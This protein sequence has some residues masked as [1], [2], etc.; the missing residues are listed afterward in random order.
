MKPFKK[1]IPVLLTVALVFSP[2]EFLSARTAREKAPTPPTALSALVID[3]A[4]GKILWSKEPDHLLPPASTT[5]LLTALVV[6]DELSLDQVVTVDS[7]VVGTPP[8][9]I[10]LRAGERF[11]VQDLLRALLIAS[12]NDAARALAIAAAGSEYEFAQKM[13]RKAK[14][15]GAHNSR[16]VKASGLPAEGQVSTAYDLMQIF[17]QVE[18]NS[19]FM[20]ALAVK[21]AVIRSLD[22]RSFRLKNH[23]KLL[24]R[25]S[26]E[27][28]GK[29][30]WTREA[31]H[32]FIG[33]IRAGGKTV[34]VSVL[35]SRKAWNDIRYFADQFI[36]VPAASSN[37]Q[38]SLNGGH[39]VWKIQTALRHAGF[40][41]REPTGYYG[42]ITKRAVYRFQKAHHLASDGVVGP[43][44]WEALRRYLS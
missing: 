31:R 10:N 40:F 25:D 34:Y 21:F 44:T 4:S 32:C 6:L 39:D 38:R 13:N 23:N 11:Y 24:W 42:L 3:G 30:G 22:G 5:K 37:R 16:F 7:S 33:R 17:R 18:G 15:I 12:A 26:R 41:K 2:S 43:T 14:E 28:I 20:R 8:S 9:R 36:G 29:T 35:G 1:A 27:I 19:F